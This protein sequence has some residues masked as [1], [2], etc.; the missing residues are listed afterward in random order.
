MENKKKYTYLL[1][2]I[3]ALFTAGGVLLGTTIS[4]GQ[5]SNYSQGE[6]NYQKIQDIIQVLDRKYVDSV[7]A[8]DL[9]EKTIQL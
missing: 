6:T 5:N 9:F 2:L 7:N 4:S 1:P 8:E 3:M